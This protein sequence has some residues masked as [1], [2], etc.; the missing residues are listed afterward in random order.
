GEELLMYLKKISGSDFQFKQ[1]NDKG[2]VIRLELSEGEKKE[3]YAIAIRGQNVILSG[4]SD[5]AVLYA[6]YDFLGRLGCVWLAPNFNYYEGLAEIIPHQPDLVFEASGTIY[7]SP[8][9]EYRILDVA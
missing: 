1:K 3:D 9:L 2:A 5:R 6:V 8:A 7:E 4:N